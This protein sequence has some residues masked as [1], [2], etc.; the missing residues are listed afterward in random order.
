MT[1]DTD[2][3][4]VD[5]DFL[6]YQASAALL[7]GGSPGTPEDPEGR[8]VLAN[9]YQRMA[10]SARGKFQPLINVRRVA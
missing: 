9:T 8:R 3:A 5:E 4:K 6:V 1:A 10:D 7:R 2:T